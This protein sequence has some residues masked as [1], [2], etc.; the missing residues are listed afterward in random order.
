M[1][2]F[3]QIDFCNTCMYACTHAVILRKVLSVVFI[4]PLVTAMFCSPGSCMSA[5]SLVITDPF[6]DLLRGESCSLD[7]VHVCHSHSTSMQIPGPQARVF[8]G[9]PP[10]WFPAPYLSY[11]DPREEQ[12]AEGCPEGHSWG[13]SGP[14]SAFSSAAFCVSLF[15]QR[16]LEVHFYPWYF[17]L[18]VWNLMYLGLSQLL[19]VFIFFFIL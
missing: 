8:A 17:N 2:F 3:S 15:H 11:R 1:G 5:V 19:D 16:Q 13:S 7:S 9:S 4:L 6:L 10:F 14:S 18:K 12:S